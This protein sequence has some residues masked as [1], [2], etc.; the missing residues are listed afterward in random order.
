MAVLGI[1]LEG[2]ESTNVGYYSNISEPYTYDNLPSKLVSDGL[3]NRRVYSLYLDSENATSGSLLFGGVDHE[4][5]EGTLQ[6]VPLIN[7]YYG[8][9]EKPVRFEITVSNIIVSAAGSEPIEILTSQ[10]YA[11][12]D[13][14]TTFTYMPT[15]ML[16]ALAS[17]FNLTYSY[18]SGVY[19]TT[20]PSD[21]QL[22]GMALTFDF[23]GIKIEVPLKNLFIEDT[24]SY[25]CIFT[26][27]DGGS[28]GI[29][30]GAN[31][32][33][34]AYVV[35]DL[36]NY[37]IG[38][39]QAKYTND[40][41]VEVIS[42]DIPGAT[43]VSDF[44]KTLDVEGIVSSYDATNTLS[45]GSSSRTRTASSSSSSSSS[46]NSDRSGSSNDAKALNV[47]FGHV[48]AVILFTAGL[49]SL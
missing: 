22:A 35:Y 37:Q 18:Y 46:S 1:G 15:R 34:S 43:S 21:A 6:L 12:L 42:S 20:C 5:Y 41:N 19:Y 36:D 38:L 31:F 23:Q 25:N 16:D 28:Q 39:A 7:T 13:S 48:F 47:S 11:N 33:R 30:L 26:V 24:G 27:L 17:S 49:V 45:A 4:K 8:I 29:V 3:I 44:D 32:L 9:L 14:G 40:T 2:L 10:F